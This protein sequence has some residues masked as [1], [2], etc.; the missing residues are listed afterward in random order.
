MNTSP[1]PGCIAGKVAELHRK[2]ANDYLMG[3]PEQD[4]EVLQET[5]ALMLSMPK[6]ARSE[7]LRALKF[8]RLMA[9]G[10]IE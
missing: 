8:I 2:A 7:A 9:I 10:E 3:H 1:A 4:C 5:V 6:A